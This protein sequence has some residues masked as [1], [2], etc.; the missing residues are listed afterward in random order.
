[1]NNVIEKYISKHIFAIGQSLI[2]LDKAPMHI[3]KELIKYYKKGN[4][5]LVFI[6]SIPVLQ[7]L[8]ITVNKLFKD[9][10]RNLYIQY[11]IVN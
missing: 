9:G 2:V 3:S 5:K 10:F 6:S 11:M 4:K 1:M 7:P 8:D